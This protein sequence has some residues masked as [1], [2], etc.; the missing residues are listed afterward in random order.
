MVYI[1]SV[2]D[3][4]NYIDDYYRRGNWKCS[5]YFVI[6]GSWYIK[7]KWVRREYSR[8][9]SSEEIEVWKLFEKSYCS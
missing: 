9:D 3:L 2:N 4:E 8:V 6:I 5:F 1:D 7:Y